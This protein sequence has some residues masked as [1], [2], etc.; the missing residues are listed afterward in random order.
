MFLRSFYQLFKDYLIDICIKYSATV[1]KTCF[2][3]DSYLLLNVENI[4]AMWK[5]LFCALR[6]NVIYETNL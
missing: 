1:G 2:I 5:H 6:H 3:N 4:G